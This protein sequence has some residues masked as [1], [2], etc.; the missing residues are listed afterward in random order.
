MPFFRVFRVFRACLWAKGIQDT[1]QA[2]GLVMHAI[3]GRAQAMRVCRAYRVQDEQDERDRQDEQDEQDE[4][5]R[6]D[7]RGG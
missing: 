4:R 5:D 6:Q 2:A 3:Q 7:E 1:Q